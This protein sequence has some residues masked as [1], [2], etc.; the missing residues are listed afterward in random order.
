MSA[1]TDAA[2]RAGA[3]TGLLIASPDGERLYRRLGW[4]PR[5]TVLTA[6]AARR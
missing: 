3:R 2:V 4:T 6:K 5:A 1:L